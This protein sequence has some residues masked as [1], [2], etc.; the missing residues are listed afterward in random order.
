M[1]LLVRPVPA[2]VGEA[3]GVECGLCA[4]TAVAWGKA[5][6]NKREHSDRKDRW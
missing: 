5:A 2:T 4:A 6:V 3:D 1:H